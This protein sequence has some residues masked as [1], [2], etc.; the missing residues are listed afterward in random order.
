MHISPRGSKIKTRVKPPDTAEDYIEA[1]QNRARAKE[2]QGEGKPFYT[3]NNHTIN[4]ILQIQYLTPCIDLYLFTQ[5]TQC[6][7]LGDFCN[8]SDLKNVDDKVTSELYKS[9]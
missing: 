3:P 4:R 9:G 1:E 5:I 8:R 2:E 7:R 6:D